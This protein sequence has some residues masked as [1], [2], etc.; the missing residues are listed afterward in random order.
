MCKEKV[1]EWLLC[2]VSLSV[3][4]QSLSASLSV[5]LDVVLCT[6]SSVCAVCLEELLVA[7]SIENI[8]ACHL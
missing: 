3:V 7:I 1:P 8:A 5:L 4:V 6:T 2:I